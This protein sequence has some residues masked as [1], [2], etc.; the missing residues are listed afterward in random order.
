MQVYTRLNKLGVVVSH[1]SALRLTQA[2]G[3]KHDLPVHK[4]KASLELEGSSEKGFVIVGD[5][6]DKRVTPRNMRIDHQV[7]SLHYFHSYASKNRI[8]TDHLD[9]DRRIKNINDLALSDILPSVED[10]SSI[11]NNF[12][13]LVARVIVKYLSHFSM[14]KKAVTNHIQHQYSR[15][16]EE[17]STVVSI[18]YN[19]C[20]YLCMY[21]NF[22]NGDYL[23][24]ST[25]CHAS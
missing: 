15:Q 20:I 19:V 6:I 13:V 16:M 10:C 5:N 17:K 1:R 24:G 3:E 8:Q 21:L 23:L 7:Q 18:M 22:N 12:T 25:W 2:M 9:D 11:R 14:F 4:W